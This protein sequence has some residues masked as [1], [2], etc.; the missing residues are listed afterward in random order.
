MT[1][2]IKL[3]I[4]AALI[5]SIFIP[6]GYFLHGERTKKRYKRS[7]AFNA[8][9]FFGIIVIAGV[10]MFVTDPVQAAQAGSD[11]GMATGLVIWLCM[12]IK[13]S[14]YR[15]ISLTIMKVVPLPLHKK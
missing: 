9:F 11:A 15:I 1:L 6:F 14:R 5:L 7:I 12:K 10:M 4:I 3:A 8:F 2:A 13:P